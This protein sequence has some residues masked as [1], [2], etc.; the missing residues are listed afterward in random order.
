MDEN[1]KSGLSPKPVTLQVIADRA[2]VTKALV[3][4]ALRGSPRVATA[5]KE[6]IQSLAKEMG[7]RSNPM[8]RALM[9]E[10]RQG[11]SGYRATL[12]FVTNL[13]TADAWQ[14]LSVYPE[15]MSGA[16]KAG[17]RLGYQIEHFWLGQFRSNPSRLSDILCAR[18]IPGILVAPLPHKDNHFNLDLSKFSAVSFGYSLK[19]PRVPRVCNN[20]VQTVRNAV[21]QLVRRGY[22]HIGFAIE[23]REFRQVNYLWKAGITV[24]QCVHP[25]LKISMFHSKSWSKSS[26]EKWFNRV[27]PEVIVGLK[28]EI[29]LWLKELELSIPEDVG[30]LHLDCR[31]NEATSGMYQNTESLGSTAVELLANLVESNITIENVQMRVVMLQ[32][33]FNEGR[34]LRPLP[35]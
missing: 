35:K 33:N 8:V 29:L 11:S 15:Y 27:R 22:Q 18:G 9:S 26:F 4:M 23:D 10:V 1:E 7:Y 32:S 3:S 34:T 30:F 5:T 6:K 24:A 2:G 28:H 14:Q 25:D 20:H 31:W 19:E 17:Q 12:A 13:S 16:Q 21:E